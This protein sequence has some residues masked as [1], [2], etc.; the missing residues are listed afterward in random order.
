MTKQT[1][2]CNAFT[3]LSTVLP[4]TFTHF[5]ARCVPFRATRLV[6]FFVSHA[7]CRYLLILQTLLLPVLPARPFT[8]PFT[9]FPTTRSQRSYRLRSAC[10]FVE[11]R[12]TLPRDLVWLVLPPYPPLY[13]S[14]TEHLPTVQLF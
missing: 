11:L 5:P 4:R 9:F 10:W 7:T 1:L 14:G 3:H 12:A 8:T 13:H 6:C 2:T